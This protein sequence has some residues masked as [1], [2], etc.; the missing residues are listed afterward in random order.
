MSRS[1]LSKSYLRE[2]LLF[3]CGLLILTSSLAASNSRI[4]AIP[5]EKRKSVSKGIVLRKIE[6]DPVKIKNIKVGSTARR[7]EDE[8]DDS[9]DWLRKLSLEIENNWNK[10]IIYLRVALSFP[11]TESSGNRMTFHVYLGNEPGSPLPPKRENLRIAPGEKVLINMADRYEWLTQFL[12][13]RQSM[14]QINKVE[15]QVGLAVSDDKTAWGDGVFFE[16][17]PYKP[18]RYIPVGTKPPTR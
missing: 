15:I 3:L 9:D 6:D 8:F 10:P 2:A 12:K 7:F 1:N 5:Q 16:Q 4:F 14:S 17:D 18:G 11:E 13:T